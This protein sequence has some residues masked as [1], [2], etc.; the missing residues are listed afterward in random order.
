MNPGSLDHSI[1]LFSGAGLPLPKQLRDARCTVVDATHRCRDRSKAIAL[2]PNLYPFS[3]QL[4]LPL[5]ELTRNYAS[6]IGLVPVTSTPYL[7]YD[8]NEYLCGDLEMDAVCH[9][10]RKQNVHLIGQLVRFSPINLL[11]FNFID[12]RIALR[13]SSILMPLRLRLGSSL[14]QWRDP[15]GKKFSPLQ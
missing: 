12:D 1:D 10:L 3:R 15:E 9:K 2:V 6:P 11:Q 8:I 5:T 4:S 7:N 13:I 14:A